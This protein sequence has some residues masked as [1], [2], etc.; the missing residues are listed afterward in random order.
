MNISFENPDKING[1]MTIVVEEA[2]Y[3][4]EVEKALKDYRKRANIP[5]FRPG[6]V[7]MGL[8]KRQFGTQL[9]MDAVNKL[10]GEN[11][12]KYIADNKIQMLGQPMA[13]EKQDAVDLEKEAP[14]TFMFDIA[15]APEFKA[16]LSGKDKVAYYEIEVDDKM[17]DQQ[18]EMFQSR[19]G[20]YDK[21][22]EFDADKRDM[23]KGDLRELDANGNTLEGGLTIEGAS[24]MPQYIK[25]EDQKNLFNGAKLGDI[26][27]WNPCA[28]YPENDA[29]VSSLLK[30][31]KEEVAEHTGNFSYQITEISRFVN[32]ENNKELWVSVYGEDAKIEDEAAFRKH[33]ADG[34]ATQLEGDSNYKFIQDVRT[35]MEKKVG[36]LAFPDELLKRIMLANNQE[37]GAEFVEKNYENSIKELTWHLIKEQLA[38][39]QGIKVED[40]DIRDSAIQMARAQFAQYGMTN[41]PEEYLTNYADEMLKQRE[42]IDSFVEAALDRKLSEKLKEVV[43][44]DKK[45]ISLEEFNKLVSAK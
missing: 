45:T 23:L 35:H 30:I 13:S 11:L 27:T 5:G 19:A 22:E 39:A 14:Y 43:K 10:L 12:Q 9:K 26:I 25:V 7:P 38:V 31:K 15:V 36:K 29:E 42:N 17:I 4:E 37:K 24:L 20:H 18:V 1:L 40:K 32:A 3:K 28:A 44:L 33:I 16:A 6:Q 21:V 8:I 41:V 34:L 2:D